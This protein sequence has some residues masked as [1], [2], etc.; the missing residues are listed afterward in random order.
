MTQE[1]KQ[2]PKYEVSRAALFFSTFCLYS[3]LPHAAVPKDCT[4]L[5]ECVFV[6]VPVHELHAW[7]VAGA[8][9]RSTPV[10]A[11]T[12]DTQPM[13]AKGAGQL[14]AYR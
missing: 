13:E 10:P 8:A 9:L 7:L 6:F 11:T 2:A 14:Q 3:I 1:R 5:S 4:P 12:G